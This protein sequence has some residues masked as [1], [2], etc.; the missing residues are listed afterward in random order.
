MAHVFVPDATLR[1]LGWNQILAAL[2]D[3]T[4]TGRGAERAVALPFLERK[5]AI[6]ESLARIDEV[7]ELLRKELTMPLGDAVD[8]RDTVQFAA[9]GAQLEAGQ[10]IAVA[11]LIRASSRVRSFLHSHRDEAP[12]LAGMAQDL[13]EATSIASRIGLA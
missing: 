6:E 1:D 11:R 7:R 13:P 12:R 10:L 4:S 8:V 5:E 9:K 3:R 2:A